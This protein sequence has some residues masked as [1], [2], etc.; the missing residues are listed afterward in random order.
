MANRDLHI[1]ILGA[2][3]SE[4]ACLGDGIDRDT[5]NGRLDMCSGISEEGIRKHRCLRN[6]IEFGF[7]GCGYT[8]G[9]EYGPDTGPTRR[10]ERD[11]EGSGRS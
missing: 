9:T 4:K 8:A 5:R 11:R 2:G 1:A 3:E 7:R 10:L 6:R